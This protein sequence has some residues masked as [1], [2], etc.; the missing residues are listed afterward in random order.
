[1]SPTLPL[2]TKERRE[3]SGWCD[4]PRAA[5]A[6]R[7]AV[8]AAPLLLAF[9]STWLLTRRWG[10]PESF[11]LAIV[12]FVVLAAVAMAV[13][14]ATDKLARRFLPLA[15]LLRLS[16]VFPDQ[17]PS[18]FI[19]A[20]RSGNSR[21][22]KKRLAQ[23]ESEEFA[24]TEADAAR[25]I[26]ELTAA[27]SRHDR[28]TQGHS[29][30]VRAYS[31]LIADEIGLSPEDSNRLQWAGL[32]HDVGK[33]KIPYEILTK[34][35]SL[36]EREY[37]IIKTHPAEGMRIAA[38]LAD[39]LGPWFGA[40]GDHHERVDG[41]GY[42]RGLR[43]NEISLGGRIVAVAAAY[44]VMTAAR[45]YKK[46]ISA[47][48]AR[49]ELARS[50][51]S[52]FD[53][54]VVRAFLNVGL[55]TVRRSMW[56]LSW[57]LQVPFFGTAVAAPVA[58]AVTVS[59]LTL[60]TATG[61]TAMNGGLTLPEIP[62]VL[63]FVQTDDVQVDVVDIVL[64]PSTVRSAVADTSTTIGPTSSTSTSVDVTLTTTTSSA[65]ATTTEVTVPPVTIETT[66][67]IKVI[68]PP[69]TIETTT[70]TTK[71]ALSINDC[72]RAQAGDLKLGD[73]D[74]AQCDLSGLDLSGGAFEG[75]DFDGAQLEA[76]TL[77]GGSFVAAS[78]VGA[79]LTN[80]TA[81][82]ADFTGAS[83]KSAGIDGTQF[84]E[85]NLTYANF[86]DAEIVGAGFDGAALTFA[87]FA[88]AWIRESSFEWVSADNTNFAGATLEFGS[89]FEASLREANFAGATLL[90]WS[91]KQA[92][93]TAASFTEAIFIKSSIKYATADMALFRGAQIDSL[94]MFGTS[95]VEADFTNAL[96]APLDHGE[97]TFDATICSNGEPTWVSCWLR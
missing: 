83:F 15:A 44:D 49:R 1:M 92:D 6:V 20:L 34:P 21:G 94:W 53:P 73:A 50:A 45:S 16:L 87:S 66:T 33:L 7:A 65:P 13:G 2:A 29:E 79:N 23:L 85:A 47:A 39:F 68:V 35:G 27:L 80:A 78:F 8:F 48:N 59:V 52:Q 77:N 63:A 3:T 10:P 62:D 75:A 90:D 38:P 96:G 51:G 26:V 31:A 9:I 28:L 18:R 17:A 70:T 88:Q 97:A 91:F 74:L 30:R 64:P 12:R 19:V 37:E 67:T 84:F 14:A 43:G 24:G 41:G 55:G 76:T 71:L 95:L 61:A 86:D 54:I 25:L 82:G 40:V 58:Q 60:A 81:H 36:T 93:L 89:M 69:V 32:I 42:P 11:P 56:P 46:P 22:L 57:A 4:N 72:E 5:F